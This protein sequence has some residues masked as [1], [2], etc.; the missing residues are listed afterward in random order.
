MVDLEI[1]NKARNL[2]QNQTPAERLL[3]SKLRANQI[4]GYKFRRQFPSGNFI[5]DF[6]CPEAQLAIEVDGS[7]HANEENQK[8][9][10]IRS[11]HLKGKG[12]QV[13]R[14]WNNDVLEHVDAVVVEIQATLE[15]TLERKQ[16]KY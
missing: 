13:I 11:Q 6:Y 14:F 15:E 10:S 2:R 12:I 1:R 3:W 7:Q 4:S 16:N 5:L 8:M 9:D